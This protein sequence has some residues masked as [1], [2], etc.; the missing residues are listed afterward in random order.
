MK[1]AI[2]FNI[3]LLLL[4]TACSETIHPTNDQLII[5]EAN[6]SLTPN[7]KSIYINDHKFIL[8][9]NEFKKGKRV[10]NLSNKEKGRI[11]GSIVV[12]ATNEMR[13]SATV[14]KIADKTF[15]IIPQPGESLQQLY[16]KLKIDEQ[17]TTVELQIDYSPMSSA[18]VK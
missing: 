9:D 18:P 17:Y 13:L 14:K 1:H 3:P 7:K 4:F 12:V 6:V 8:L 15:L 10:F 16:D 11:K 2:I 5:K